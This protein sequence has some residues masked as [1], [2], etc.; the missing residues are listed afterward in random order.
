MF[1]GS[2][3]AVVTPM[4]PDGAIDDEAW[5]RLLDFHAENGTSA[6][7]VGG[8]TGE[9]ATLT[10]A[11]LRE[12]IVSARDHLRGRVAIVAGAGL[13]STAATIDRVRWIGELGIDGV[14]VVTP[15]YV[16]PTQEGLFRHFAAV[17][18]AASLPVI[19][20]NVPG[21]T[22]VDLLPATVARLAA[23]PRIAAIKE[24]VP[25]P[26]RVREILALA[27]ELTVLSGDDATARQAL[28][29]GARGVISVTANV[30]PQRMARM[31]AAAVAGDADEA[32][33]LDATLAELHEVLF[34]E[35]NP[36]PVKFVL[37]RMG[38]ID[39]GI[40]LP[41]TPLSERYHG[42]LLEVMQRAGLECGKLPTRQ[43]V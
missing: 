41:L 14:L 10:D 39:S 36:I 29:A 33:A 21:R 18:E 31:V 24:A 3:V 12:L 32:A 7:I 4:R 9:S 6:V 23:V 2:A 27:P 22:A 37:E 17:A 35:P 42:R 30:V 40:R 26:G 38:L 11:E 16:K 13:S 15:A 34:I 43:E 25:G 5:Y 28:L 19:L 8:T 20:Y 1:S